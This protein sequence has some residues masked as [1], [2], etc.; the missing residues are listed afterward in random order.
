MGGEEDGDWE[1]NEGD[2][3][4]EELGLPDDGEEGVG[5]EEEEEEKD[6]G[7]VFSI[8][9]CSSFF[10]WARKSPNKY[11]VN[12]YRVYLS[13]AFH[14]FFCKKRSSTLIH[15]T[16]NHSTFLTPSFA[17]PFCTNTNRVWLTVIVV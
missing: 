1:D 14:L 9:A 7:M 15:F 12:L 13:L 11:F 2:D 17:S 3:K 8:F 5:K 4:E 16:L 6:D 10:W